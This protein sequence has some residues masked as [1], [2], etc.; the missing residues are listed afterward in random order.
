MVVEVEVGR[1]ST[2]LSI[3]SSRPQLAD[4]QAL[5]WQT[6]TPITPSARLLD[7]DDQARWQQWL[8]AASVLLGVAASLLAALLFEWAPRK[9]RPG[10][11]VSRTVV[12]DGAARTRKDGK[13]W[14][15]GLTLALLAAFAMGRIRKR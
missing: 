1:L 10:M 11:Q 6:L 14:A 9:R 13:R 5:G 7:L 12:F 3:E 8:V 4:S 2:R 15:I